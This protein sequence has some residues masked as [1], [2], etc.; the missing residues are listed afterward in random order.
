MTSYLNYNILSLLHRGWHKQRYGINNSLTHGAVRA[1]GLMNLFEIE[2][3]GHK[4]N[5]NV[6]AEWKYLLR[7]ID[8]HTLI[9]SLVPKGTG[10]E[11]F[12]STRGFN[13]WLGGHPRC[14]VFR[15]KSDR[16]LD[17]HLVTSTKN[18]PIEF[19]NACL[20]S[21]DPHIKTI[22]VVSLVPDQKLGKLYLGDEFFFVKNFKNVRIPT[23]VTIDTKPKPAK[24]NTLKN[25][26]IP[27]A[28]RDFD[29]IV[30]ERAAMKAEIF[31]L[32]TELKEERNTGFSKTPNL[33]SPLVY[34]IEELEVDF[35]KKVER[36]YQG[37]DSD[38]LK[39]AIEFSRKAFMYAMNRHQETIDSFQKL[40]D[41]VDPADED[42]IQRL[43]EKLK[44]LKE[45][46]MAPLE[47]TPVEVFKHKTLLK[48]RNMRMGAYA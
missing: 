2:Y 19:L 16:P 23:G 10:S 46:D 27:L 30:R 1:L 28:K 7:E 26:Q 48:T 20:T 44:S 31:K 45:V 36:C 24:K 32:R 29:E 40:L 17:I 8:E 34:T 15:D 3:I 47:F 21:D 14:I 13:S 41:D 6:M 37:E 5:P 11:K 9:S 39:K 42:E 25:D 33:G 12:E 35:I 18:S 4:H 22:Q 38:S 43:N